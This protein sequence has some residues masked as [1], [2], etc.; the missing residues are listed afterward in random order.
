MEWHVTD[1]QN[2]AIIDREI[3]GFLAFTHSN[4]DN[5][6]NENSHFSPAEYEIV[7][8]VIYATGDFE[9]K[10][11]VE[12]SERALQASAAALASRS[13]VIVDDAKVQAGIAEEIQKTFANA[14]Y[15][16]IE[17]QTR[18]QK[19]KTRVA[20]GM[21]TLAK[22][23][24]EGI[25]VVGQAISPLT[26]LLNLIK[27]ETIRPVLIIATPPQFTNIDSIKQSL[28][29]F[30]IPNITIKSR[31]GG[32]TVAAAILDGLVDLAWEAYG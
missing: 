4:D 17:A 27:S 28:Q 29:E 15:C 5:P 32:A 24:P 19:D 31:K 18:P 3:G 12:F 25:F 13:T 10:S 8:R 11:L 23:Y 22:R 21:E 1:A 7:R 9:Y 16:A 6:G 14:V 26:T 20:W 30:S 2:L